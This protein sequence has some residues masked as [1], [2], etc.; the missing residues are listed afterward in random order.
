MN[1][2]LVQQQDSA[3]RIDVTRRWREESS[4]SKGPESDSDY[5]EAAQKQGDDLVGRLRPRSAASNR[6]ETV[7]QGRE[8]R[9]PFERPKS[10]APSRRTTATS[11]Q[12]QESA[13]RKLFTTPQKTAPSTW[14][15]A[16][17]TRHADATKG[18]GQDHSSRRGLGPSWKRPLTLHTEAWTPQWSA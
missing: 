12:G 9:R 7:S 4:S 14:T 8:A 15:E 13:Q 6:P 1:G 16:W 2:L 5:D 3:P 18:R 10:A 17:A 11:A